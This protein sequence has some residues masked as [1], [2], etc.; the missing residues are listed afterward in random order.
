MAPKRSVSRQTLPPPGL[1]RC[2]PFAAL[3]L[4]ESQCQI[5]RKTKCSGEKALYSV[6]LPRC[7]IYEVLMRLI[8]NRP[9]GKRKEIKNKHLYSYFKKKRIQRVSLGFL[10]KGAVG[11]VGGTTQY[12]SNLAW[13]EWKLSSG[14]SFAGSLWDENSDHRAKRS[15][16]PRFWIV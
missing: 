12:F 15:N 2:L 13:K 6:I 3:P 8:G 5:T 9:R 14:I 7:K 11:S 1:G 10:C 16:R 4:S